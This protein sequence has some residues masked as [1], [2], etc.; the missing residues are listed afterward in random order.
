VTEFQIGDRVGCGA[1]CGAC[2]KCENCKNDHENHCP[3]VIDT[4]N[5]KYEDGERTQGGY[6]D[7]KRFHKHFAFHIPENI[8]SAEAAPLLCA[9]AT[10]YSPL[11][12]YGVG[13]GK[14]VAVIGI[15]GLGHL[16]IMFAAKLGAEVV[17]IGRSHGKKDLCVKL[18][19][20]DYMSMDDEEA[21]KKYKGYFDVLIMCANGKNMVYDP[22]L[23]LGKIDAYFILV[24]LPENELTIKPF[25]LTG[26]RVHLVGSNVGSRKEIIDM[27][28]FC[29][30]ND[31][32][33]MIELLPMSEVNEGIRK[34][35][36]NDVKFRVVL[37][38]GK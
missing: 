21:T 12:R 37:E 1:Q 34:V 4:Y 15:G 2:L 33:P 14:K 10:T 30:K 35:Q 22:Y 23:R 26:T 31:V 28:E 32:R 13:P 38:Q 16:A 18:G 24:A 11:K 9:G 8:S 6:A 25:T 20:K 3:S 36:E 5:D 27:L 7:K 17:G 29:S 19:A